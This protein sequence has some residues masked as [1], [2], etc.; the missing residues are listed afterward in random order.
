MK[1]ESKIHLKE[2]EVKTFFRQRRFNDLFRKNRKIKQL[3][4]NRQNLPSLRRT[5][6]HTG[7]LCYKSSSRPHDFISQLVFGV[8]RV[9]IKAVDAEKRLAK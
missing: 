2:K 6:T 8:T 5:S 1:A 7:I 9:K 4:F 3:G